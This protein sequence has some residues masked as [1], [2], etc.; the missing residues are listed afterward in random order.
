MRAGFV[1]SLP[2]GSNC[3]ADLFY[4]KGLDVVVKYCGNRS[5]DT[6]FGNMIIRDYFDIKKI[7]ESEGIRVPIT[8]DVFLDRSKRSNL[9]IVESYMG[10][11]L[12][13]ILKEDKRYINT[14]VHKS[15]AFIKSLPQN[16]PLDT[17]PGNIVIDSYGEIAFIDLIPPN[18]WKY[19]NT[20]WELSMS[21]AFKTTSRDFDYP[22]KQAAYFSTQGRIKRFCK[23]INNLLI[24]NR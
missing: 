11:S 14:L 7:L 15:A 22:E 3:I 19:R 20:E 8:Y 1:R 6:E 9:Y 5:L 17:N 24:A 12:K 4:F 13:K 16:V 21:K 2:K 10:R 18:Q 23:H